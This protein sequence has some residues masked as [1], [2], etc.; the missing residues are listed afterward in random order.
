MT[1][2][3]DLPRDKKT[4]NLLIDQVVFP[5]HDTLLKPITVDGQKVEKVIV[6]EPTVLDIETSNQ[7]ATELDKTKRILAQVMELKPDDIKQFGSRD[8][9]RLSEL[10]AAFL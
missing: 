7:E 2:Y 9:T 8:F 4:E 1:D 5:I 10:V 3:K 6:Q